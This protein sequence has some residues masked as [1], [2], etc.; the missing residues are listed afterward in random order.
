[1]Q[2]KKIYIASSFRHIH[3]VQLLERQ[4]IAMGYEIMDWTRKAS[5]PEGLSPAKRREWMDTD[6]NGGTVFAFCHESC[7]SADLV[8]YLGQ[9]GQDA[10]VEIGMAKASNIPV[11][12]IRGPLEYAG[13]MLYGSC[14]TWVDSIGHALLILEKFVNCNDEDRHEK[15]INLKKETKK[16]AKKLEV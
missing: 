14:T 4:L 5:V 12:G 2:K 9:S 3:A 16:E 10:G 11:L 7:T 15:L 13:L 6:N 8:I 1:M